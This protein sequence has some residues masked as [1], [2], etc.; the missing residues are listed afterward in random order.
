MDWSKKSRADLIEEGRKRGWKCTGWSKPQLVEKL[1]LQDETE[2]HKAERSLD[3][4][5]ADEARV[6]SVSD[7]TAQTLEEHAVA[8]DTLTLY[9][10]EE[11]PVSPER[12]QELLEEA[13]QHYPDEE[14]AE[15]PEEP[16]D[17]SGSLE[18]RPGGGSGRALSGWC[19]NAPLWSSSHVRCAG[20]RAKF[21]CQC[22][23]H[24]DGW[25]Q[26]AT[27]EG[28]KLNKFYS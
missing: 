24:A 13:R 10:Q 8:L 5:E 14:Q 4:L 26:P 17:E 18:D 19:L 25:E 20:G 9:D 15:T 1:R 2:T 23:C 21:V 22:E 3:A 28:A 27:P 11:P 6:I 7:A 12:L 16:E